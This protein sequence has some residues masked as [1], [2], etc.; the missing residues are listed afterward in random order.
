MDQ[1][2]PDAPAEDA[3]EPVTLVNPDGGKRRALALDLDLVEQTRRRRA[4][5]NPRLSVPAGDRRGLGTLHDVEP[6]FDQS[7]LFDHSC[8]G[9][10]GRHDR[11]NGVHQNKAS[12]CRSEQLDIP[13]G[14]DA[15]VAAVDSADD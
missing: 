10:G 3:G 6:R 9:G 11:L 14:V 13:D 12:R 8:A 4:L 1:R 2:C 7:R 5:Q 15:L